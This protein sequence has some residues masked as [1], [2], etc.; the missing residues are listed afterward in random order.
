MAGYRNS[1]INTI[2]K[3]SGYLPGRFLRK[4]TGQNLLLPFYHTVSDEPLPHIRN[5]YQVKGISSFKKDLEFL[6]KNYEPVS[7]EDLQEKTR[8]QNSFSKPSFLLTFDDGLRE[9]HDIIAPELLKK[10]I[11][12]VCFLNSA[13]IDNKALFFRYKVSLLIDLFDQMPA[14]LNQSGILKEFEK[15]GGEGDFRKNLLGIKY[16]NQDILDR[17][18]DLTD[19]SF[20]DF[21]QKQRPYLSS[22][23]ITALV[24]KGFY[25]GGHSIDH[26]E[27]RYI[28]IQEQVR[29]TEV[30]IREVSDTFGLDYRCF[31]FP[32][33]DYGVSAR[34]FDEIYK[35]KI[36]ELTFGGAGIKKDSY[37]RHF[38][39][40]SFE[41]K[42]I[43]AKEIVNSELLYYLLKIPTGKNRIKRV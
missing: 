32:F 2:H 5:L 42:E 18:A 14:L 4:L 41:R 6:L 20:N 33:T 9:F 31:S 36:A 34:F 8:N 37:D 11:P 43:P 12:A 25:F 29:Q 24:Q 26:P 21:L 19:L 10:G 17:I 1:F 22:G 38:H 27:Y 23:E 15:S 40:V 30:S 13:F 35:N 3:I 16:H 28:Q 39:R 7:Y